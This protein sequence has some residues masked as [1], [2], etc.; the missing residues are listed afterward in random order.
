MWT[1]AHLDVPSTGN[2]TSEFELTSPLV[3]FT[4][5]TVATGPLCIGPG[6][7]HEVVV[8]MGIIVEVILSAFEV[9]EVS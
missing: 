3:R 5:S 9:I 8:A 2:S 1:T 7:L 6:M 4:A